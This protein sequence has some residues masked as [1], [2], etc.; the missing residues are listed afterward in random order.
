[1]KKLIYLIAIV[2]LLPVLSG[3]EKF[4]DTESFTKKNAETFPLSAD[5]ANQS[6]TG[7][8]AVLNAYDP[9]SNNFMVSELAADYRF[10]GGGMDDKISQATHHLL[11]TDRNA[12]EA[13]WAQNYKGIARANA[14]ITALETTMTKGSAKNQ[15]IGEAKFLRALFYYD[16]VQLLGNVP[17]VKDVPETVQEAKSSPPQAQPDSV[18]IQIATDLWDAYS[19]MP[20]SK[21]NTYPS[22]TI[23][24]GA[25]EGLLARV[26]LFYTGFYQKETLPR[27]GGQITRDDV[28]AAL[29]DCIDHG[30]YQLVNDF[31][32]LWPYSNVITKPDYPYDAVKLPKKNGTVGAADDWVED[33]NNREQVFVIKMSILTSW[34]YPGYAN[35]FC[36]FFGLRNGNGTDY[37]NLFPMGEGYGWGPVNPQLWSD[38]I[39]DEPNDMRRVASI[40]NQTNSVE[41]SDYDGEWGADSQMEETGLWQKKIVNIKAYGKDGDPENLYSTFTSAP[42]Y[43][44]SSTSD[45]YQIGNATD[46]TLIRYADILLMYSEITK[47]ADGMNEVRARVGLPPVAYSDDA[48]RKERLHEL[49]FEG[50]RW[51]DI[52]RWHIAEQVLGQMYGTPICNSG[53]WTTMRQQGGA[54]VVARYKAT[55]GFWMIPQQEIDLSNGLLKQNPGWETNALFNAWR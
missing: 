30:G 21:W 13:L 2:F 18:Y 50:Q 8:Y 54:D 44:S 32:S 40:Y 41:N 45:D 35:Q 22:G 33:G 43:Y 48:L 55:N 23:T 52:R 24:K 6:L 15:K 37:N 16:L 47:T 29:K 38:W 10:G 49:A 11:Y 20:A 31:R 9:F 36:C 19:T 34:D 46:L 51:S 53:V 7:T 26:W 14:A 17:L 3:C 4:L 5:D 12:F 28:A 25:V 42:E 27:D 39:K 1:M